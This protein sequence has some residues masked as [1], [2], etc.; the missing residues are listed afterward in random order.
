M[1][2]GSRNSGPGRE[3]RLMDESHAKG[4]AC[5]AARSGLTTSKLSA[6]ACSVMCSPSRGRTQPTPP[7]AHRQLTGRKTHAQ[8]AI[9]AIGG[10]GSTGAG[11]AS[12]AAALASCIWL[13]ACAWLHAPP[14]RLLRYSV[15]VPAEEA[16]IVLVLCVLWSPR[17]AFTSSRRVAHDTR[18]GRRRT[19]EPR[20]LL[21]EAGPTAGIPA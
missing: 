6:A 11:N 5:T 10:I 9:A 17:E 19:T 12:G 8:A 3:T 2:Q 1:L 16:A 4:Q 21:Q 15:P 18:E 7:D 14:K 20:C 13:L